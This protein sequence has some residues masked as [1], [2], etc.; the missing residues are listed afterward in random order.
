VNPPEYLLWKITYR[1]HGMWWIILHDGKEVGRCMNMTSMHYWAV[2]VEGHSRVL[3]GLASRFACTEYVLNWLNGP[4][5]TPSEP[6]H[7][8]Y[9]LD[10]LAWSKKKMDG[11]RYMRWVTIG[12]AVEVTK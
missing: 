8:E 2:H 4:D 6:S 11:F 1:K 12:L 7:M 9:S 5:I 3:R 10:G